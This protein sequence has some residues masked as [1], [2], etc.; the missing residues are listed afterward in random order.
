MLEQALALHRQGR[1]PEAEKAY[2]AILA[3]DPSNAEVGHL[4]GTLALDAGLPQAAVPILE[5][6]VTLQ[7]AN[8]AFHVS[9][10]AI[11]R[12]RCAASIRP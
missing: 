2:R 11:R 6:V 9:L 8:P 12:M 5:H 4:L 7:P 3:R 10:L 1:L